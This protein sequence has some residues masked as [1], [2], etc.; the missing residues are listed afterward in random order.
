MV[1]LVSRHPRA[2]IIHFDL[3]SHIPQ[4][5]GKRFDLLMLTGN[6]RFHLFDFA[7]LLKEFVKQ[8]RVYR[9]VAYGIYLTILATSHQIY[10]F[11][12]LRQ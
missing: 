9:L 2:L 1:S 6:G 3:R 11:Y 10:V 5:S 7:M 12:P 8:H 4:A